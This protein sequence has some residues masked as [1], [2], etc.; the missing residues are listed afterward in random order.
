MLKI[1][2]MRSS[3]GYAVANQFTVQNGDK[4]TFQSYETPI[5]E[6]DVETRQLTL[7]GNWWNCSNTT[8]R[9]FKKFIN[10]E[11]SMTYDSK[12]DFLKKIAD[13]ENIT[14]NKEE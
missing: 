13:N 10:E 12:K 5:C 8:R 4:K 9:Y 6:W 11:T 3:A 2:N 14:V 7:N 1:T